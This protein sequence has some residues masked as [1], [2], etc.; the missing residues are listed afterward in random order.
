VWGQFCGALTRA[1]YPT[2]GAGSV[3]QGHVRPAAT[4][5]VL[6][7]LD[8]TIARAR[9]SALYAERLAAVPLRTLADLRAV[10]LTTRADLQQAGAHGTR[11]VPL[12]Q[13][14]HYGESSGTSGAT[15]STWLTAADF[16]R[17][18]RALRARHPDV[19]APG[20]V[21]LNRFPFMA[22]PAHLIQLIA[23]QGGGVAIPAGNIN[24][25]VPFP[26]ALELARRTGAHVLAG[27][28]MEPVVLGEIARAAGVDVRRDLALDTFFLGGSSLPPALQR[29]L[30]RT[31][32]ARVIELYGSTETML[33]GTSCPA[34][35]LHLEPALVYAEIL[36]P[37]TGEPAAEGGEGAL[38]VTTLGVEGSPLIRLDT[39]DVV[40]RLPP[41]PCGDT[42]P[43]IL[44]LGR[45]GEVVTLGARR[46][47][48]H[49][50]LDAAAAAADTLDSGV[51]FVVVLPDRLLVRI[52]AAPQHA[53]EDPLAVL[54]AALGDVPLE[55][56]TVA[57]G[58]LLD[59][60][61]LGRSPH[62][63]KPV[64]LSDWTRPGRRILTVVEGMIEWPRP[65]AS[66]GRRW[67]G[68][69]WRTAR[70]RRR[71]VRRLSAVER[72][73]TR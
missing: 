66:E 33:L 56:E 41:C 73:R 68:R 43:A 27:M 64:V 15:T 2:H 7:A 9:R 46:L 8:A 55:V 4:P 51:F 65:S 30:T 12:S 34:G 38:V 35:T 14:V 28:P 40:R 5:D 39:G 37:A 10:P 58:D 1:P 21:I 3:S 70:R 57:R 62:V 47:H 24:W 48:T 49:A 50:L 53:G 71:L 25:D 59:V 44:V 13:A 31:W 61:L 19:F 26:R 20:R 36:D 18:A 16:D 22:A 69:T 63:Y 29:R 45:T 11:A 42:R 52:E 72:D 32:G 60:E 54:R 6:A 23:Q 17:D 67:L